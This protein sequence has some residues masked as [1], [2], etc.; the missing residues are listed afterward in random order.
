MKHRRLRPILLV[1][2]AL[3]LLTSALFGIMAL[4][5]I[6]EFTE[7]AERPV[8]GWM[9]PRYVVAVYDVD[10]AALSALLGLEPDADPRESIATLSYAAG[11][12][13]QQVL[14]EIESLVTAARDAE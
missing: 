10:P 3:A 7:R 11:R 1:A 13:P 8:A 5:S 12:P 9:T 14:S 4:W 2:F 6:W